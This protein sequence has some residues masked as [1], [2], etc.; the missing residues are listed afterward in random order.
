VSGEEE[1]EAGR[2]SPEY[3]IHYEESRRIG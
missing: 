2:G 3:S 1:G